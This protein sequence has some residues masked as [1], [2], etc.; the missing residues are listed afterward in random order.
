[1]TRTLV[2]KR[3]QQPS[4]RCRVSE[5]RSKTGRPSGEPLSAHGVTRRAGDAEFHPG[6]FPREVL[7]DYTTLFCHIYEIRNG[8]TQI[9]VGI[10]YLK[11]RTF[12][13]LAAVGSL[14]DFLR[15]FRVTGTGDPLLQLQ[16]QMRFLAFTGQFVLLEYDPLAPAIVP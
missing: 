11:F 14:T 13:H 12:E 6:P 8:N 3:Q 4:R 7:Q 16:G 9:E 10:A 1:M 2:T 15:S 5:V